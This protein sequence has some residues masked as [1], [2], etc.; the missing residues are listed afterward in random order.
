MWARAGGTMGACGRYVRRT[1]ASTRTLPV[2]RS[3]QKM[4]R[5][6]RSM[7]M[8][9]GSMSP[10]TTSRTSVEPSWQLQ[11]R[12]QHVQKTEPTAPGASVAPSPNA[13]ARPRGGWRRLGTHALLSGRKCVAM[14]H[15]PEAVHSLSPM[16]SVPIP[17]P[18]RSERRSVP[19]PKVLQMSVC[20]GGDAGGL[21]DER[22]GSPS[23]LPCVGD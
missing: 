9:R 6:A 8:P 18:C 20:G 7:A 5:L 10:R 15:G 16:G 21:G 17:L 3:V 22:R 12:P 2:R 1:V 14:P 13:R 11:I 19:C 4:R 23:I